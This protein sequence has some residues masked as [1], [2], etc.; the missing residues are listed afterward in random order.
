MLPFFEILFLLIFFIKPGTLKA[1]EE[2]H[3]ILLIIALQ[4]ISQNPK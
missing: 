4:P 3:S 2:G 1:G